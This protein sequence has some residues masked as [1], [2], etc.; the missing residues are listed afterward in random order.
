MK[1]SSLISDI[2]FF[3]NRIQEIDDVLVEI[4]YELEGDFICKETIADLNFGICMLYEEGMP[5]VEKL[6][7]TKRI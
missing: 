3:R 1:N 5:F 4:K 6:C 2:N 7:E